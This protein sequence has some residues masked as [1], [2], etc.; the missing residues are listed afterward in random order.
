MKKIATISTIILLSAISVARAQIADG[1]ITIGNVTAQREGDAV[2]VSYTATIAPKAVK[3]NYTL[4][5]APVI[6]GEG[7]RQSLPAVAVHGPGSRIARERREIAYGTLPVYENATVYSNGETVN[8]SATVPFQTWMHGSSIVF[9]SIQAGCCEFGE[10]ERFVAARGILPVPLPPAPAPAPV[11]QQV[12]QS[13]GDS[14]A[15]VFAFVAPFSEY[16]P[17][18]RVTD[19]DREN[20][21]EIYF[22]LAL[23]DIDPGYL[24]N[25][26]NL[27]DLIGAIRAIT[28]SSDSR[29]AK[30]VVAGFASPEGTIEINDR[31]AINRAVALKEY[32]ID[33]TVIVDDQVALY[34]GAVDW[35]G[36]RIR[37]ERGT[38][39]QRRALLDLIDN[40]PER[41]TGSQPGR[42]DALKRL[43]GGSTYRYL[44]AEHF[45][46]LRTGAF[47]KVFYDCK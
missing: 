2:R 34:N 24:D 42:L 18:F 46:Y 7:F 13:V 45:P 15:N 17:D 22:P 36:L 41:G 11:P 33:N 39:P 6:E 28:A 44:Q 4:L 1:G 3:R 14:L 20:G 25:A 21:L 19:E 23:Y 37:I 10:H 12:R 31:L 16:D 30:I 9:E 35:Q 27:A 47:I 26:A 5:L 43:N 29:V 40:T 32:I 8:G 38:L